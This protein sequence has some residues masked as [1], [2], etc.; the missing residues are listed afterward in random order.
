MNSHAPRTQL[1]V[2]LHGGEWAWRRALRQMLLERT[3]EQGTH[4][5][6]LV[7][8]LSSGAAEAAKWLTDPRLTLIVST[9]DDHLRHSIAALAP[10]VDVLWLDAGTAGP[11]GDAAIRPIVAVAEEI[12]RRLRQVG[13][14]A[15]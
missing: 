4:T 6:A 11:A 12:L 1:S 13:A 14:D 2:L 8:L 15:R 10:T 9:E 5:P 7:V 3:Q